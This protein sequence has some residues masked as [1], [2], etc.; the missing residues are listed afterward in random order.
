MPRRRAWRRFERRGGPLALAAALALGCTT[1]HGHFDHDASVD[2]SA[3]RNY[4]IVLP[5]APDGAAGLPLPSGDLAHSQLIDRRVQAALQRELAAKGL[6]PA[7]TTETADLIVAFNVSTRAA[8]RPEFY[9]SDVG[10][11]WPYGWWHDHWDAV[12]TRIYTEGLMI[13]D[14]IDA[15]SRRLVWR[16]WTTDPLPS[17]DDVS[18]VVEHAVHEIFEGYPPPAQR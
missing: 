10:P 15:E 16:G 5:A 11:Y 13:V 8:S 6:E 9:P 1:T 17:S 12:Y 2:F 18:A 7:P 3:Y 4:A 14:L